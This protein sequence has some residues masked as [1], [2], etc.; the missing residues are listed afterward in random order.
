MARKIIRAVC[1]GS[2]SPKGQQDSAQG[3]NLVLTLGTNH[4]KRLALNGRQM[5]RP[6]QAKVGPMVQL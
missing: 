3:F 1:D 4:Q 6:N 2:L 5:E